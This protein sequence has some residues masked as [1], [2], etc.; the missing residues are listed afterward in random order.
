MVL[1]ITLAWARTVSASPHVSEAVDV[2]AEGS[3]A[4]FI[5]FYYNVVI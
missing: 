1:Q 4:Y 5:D 2:V 3:T